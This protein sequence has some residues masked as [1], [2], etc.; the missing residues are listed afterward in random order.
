ML[1]ISVSPGVKY[2]TN[3]PTSGVD[4]LFKLDYNII[5]KLEAYFLYRYKNKPIDSSEPNPV[6]YVNNNIIEDYRFNISY[7]VNPSLTLRDRVEFL[8]HYTQN[9]STQNGYSHVSG[10]DL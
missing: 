6:D 3:A 7:T 2:E 4:Y 1:I 10:R 5:N 9:N 8:T